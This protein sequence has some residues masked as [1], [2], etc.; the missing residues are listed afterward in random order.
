MQLTKKDKNGQCVD[1]KTQKAEGMIDKKER[2]CCCS[3]M[4]FNRKARNL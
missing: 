4:L 3:G 1:Q 2:K